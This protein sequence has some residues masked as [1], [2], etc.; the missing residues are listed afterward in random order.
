MEKLHRIINLEQAR[1]RTPNQLPYYLV[2]YTNGYPT[3]SYHD[4][5][6][7]SNSWGG[8]CVDLLIPVNE[9][10]CDGTDPC[11]PELDWI[12]Q[13]YDTLQ[14]EPVDIVTTDEK[15]DEC[16]IP[17][18]WI[19]Y[20]NLMKVY[21]WLTTI[22]NNSVLIYKKCGS[23]FKRVEDMELTYNICD[24][25]FQ[26]Y[27]SFSSASSAPTGTII[28]VT[29][30]YSE[31]IGLFKDQTNV[32]SF[33]RFM[34]RLINEGLFEPLSG[35]T[36]YL[37]VEFSITSTQSDLGL[38]TPLIQQWEPKK[39]YYLGEVV[40]YNNCS[41]VLRTCDN[42]DYEKYE[43]T[44]DLLKNVLNDTTGSYNI[45]TSV[46][47][48]IYNITWAREFNVPGVFTD[49]YRNY[50]NYTYT[51]CVLQE[52]DSNGLIK[53][54]FIY[55]YYK[56]HFDIKTKRTTFDSGENEHWYRMDSV[57]EDNV[58]DTETF[59][60]MAESKL[61]TLKRKISSVDDFGNQLEFIVANFDSGSTSGDT[62]WSTS[63]D[64]SGSTSGDTCDGEMY[65]MLGITNEV[66]DYDDENDPLLIKHG[67]GDELYSIRY[68]DDTSGWYYITNDSGITSYDFCLEQGTIEFTYYI[69]CDID[70]IY[71]PP[72]S[73]VGNPIVTKTRVPYTGV[74]Y[75]E[76]WAFN[77]D[78]TTFDYAGKKM[79]CEYI[80]LESLNNASSNIDI[81]E[82]TPTFSL[83][84]YY[85][86]QTKENDSLIAPIYKDEDLL[87][88][89]DINSLTY[90][91][92]SKKYI[93]AINANIER[94]T[95]ASFERHNI[96]GEIKTFADLE[97][98][99]NNFFNL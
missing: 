78:T 98:Y 70:Y 88:I 68:K 19:R 38:A 55:P 51:R 25:V 15:G 4:N 81:V 14:F 49:D 69:G 76:E 27:P 96:L 44:G 75:V 87:G 12:P 59:T 97:N 79:T 53:Y 7:D 31:F 62:I 63:G 37:D 18:Y 20:K 16:I 21:L 11:A 29:P 67:H 60:G 83:V 99:R 3:C 80:H 89:Q 48:D 57:L 47:N 45:V 9:F 26:L 10:D 64:T 61:T 5:P 86:K 13:L 82:N 43:I 46:P 94:G 90:D 22:F 24:S 66:I 50:Y 36:P 58:G 30:L 33:C 95:A 8:Y 54:S 72:V 52:T 40:L 1:N 65:Y 77:K 6:N 71:T 28:G 73:G 32:T 56:G 35:T 39:K 41:Y 84:T 93:S 42:G 74:K 92:F 17:G 91:L 23:N 34:D 2:D 85:G